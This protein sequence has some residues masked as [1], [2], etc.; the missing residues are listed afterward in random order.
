M[1]DVA[2]DADGVTASIVDR[3]TGSELQVRAAYVLGADG[4]HSSVRQAVG[5]ATFGKR[6][7]SHNVLIHFRA[8]LAQWFTNRPP[9]MVFIAGPEGPGPLLTVNGTDEWLYMAQYDPARGQAPEDFTA[10]RTLTLVRAIIGAADLPVEV[11]GVSPWTANAVIAERYSVGRVF[12]AGDAAHETTPAGGFGM[13]TGV[14]DVHNLAWKLAAVLHGWADPIL[15]ETYE[16]ERRPVGEAV[17]QQ[18]LRNHAAVER[19]GQ[20][21]SVRRGDHPAGGQQLLSEWG[22]IFGTAYCSAALVPDGS[23]APAV[24]DPVTDYVPSARP[25][26][27]APHVWLHRDSQRFSTL[28]LFDGGF[29]LLTGQYGKAWRSAGRQVAGAVGL[30]LS[31]YLIGPEGDATDPS[32]SWCDVYGIDDGG[33]VL[34][35]PDGHVAWRART[36]VLEPTTELRTALDQVLG[37]SR[38]QPQ[39]GGTQQHR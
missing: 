25:G 4:A 27:R 10:A 36:S 28:D 18:S 30:P 29:V 7:L 37:M 26:H 23:R 16:T 19:L 21:A 39:Y 35:R 14:Q 34:V 6:G 12:L 1:I 20:P 13:N 3:G 31:S 22:L 8:D 24:T 11:L 5:I 33:A 2:Q 38:H 32:G 9:Y 17:T 15:L